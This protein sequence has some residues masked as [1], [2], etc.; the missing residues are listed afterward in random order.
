M[1]LSRL[2]RQLGRI[3]AQIGARLEVFVGRS[4]LFAASLY[5]HKTQCGNP[6]CRCARGPYRHRQWC[7]S[8]VEEGRSRTRAVPR[9]IRPEV[10]RLTGDYRRVRRAR[11]EVAALFG[12]L[13]EAADAL[14]QARRT[15]GTERFARLVARARGRGPAPHTKD[16]G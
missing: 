1:D 8:F 12:E 14:T 16:G 15:A 9:S 11:R 6:R 4:P 7:V 5:E 3:Y 10:E 13:L 2:R